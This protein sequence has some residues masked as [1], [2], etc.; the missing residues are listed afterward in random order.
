MMM[1]KDVLAGAL[2]VLFDLDNSRAPELQK[3]PKE[4]LNEIYEGVLKN[5][6]AYRDLAERTI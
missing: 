2:V 5:A 1:N 3:L 6:K 4:L